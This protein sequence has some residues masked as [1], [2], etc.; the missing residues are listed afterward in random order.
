MRG[1]VDLGD[2]LR[3]DS[4]VG[5]I[6]EAATAAAGDIADLTPLLAGVVPRKSGRLQR[7]VKGKR[8]KTATGHQV[9]V[10]VSARGGRKTGAY[11]G[12][13]VNNGTGIYG[14]RGQAIR[15]RS[16]PYFVLNFRGVELRLPSVRGQRPA[17]FI[18]RVRGRIDEQA[19][20]AVQ[21]RAEQA[22]R[23]L[24]REM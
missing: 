12:H 7:A 15:P 9:T 21:Q 4:L 2:E 1:R 16:A 18:E 6:D 3:A 13:M 10:G 19:D 5:V 22:A 8:R 17:R 24:E 23:Q 11:Y 20:R 14:P